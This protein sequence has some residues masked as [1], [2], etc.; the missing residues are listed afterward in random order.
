MITR[1]DSL[2]IKPEN[3]AFFSHPPIL[4]HI[5]RYILTDEEYENVKKFYQT[6]KLENLAELN[7]IYN[8]QDTIVLCEIFEQHSSHLQNLFKFNLRKC[9][10]ASSSSGC[11]H[12]DKSK[13]CIAL[14]TDT[15]HVRVFEKTL[16]GGFSCVNTRLAF[17]TEILLKDDKKNDK[18]LF[19]LHID[20]KKQTKR[21]SSK[22]LKMDENNQYG[23]AMT[24]PLSYSCMK[25]QEHP[26]SLIEFNKILDKISHE[27]DIGHLFIVDKKFHDVNPKA[28][29]F[30]E[31]YPPIFEKNKKTDLYKRSTLQ[32]M[33]IVVRDEDKYKINSLPYTSKTHSTLKE[34]RFIP[35]YAKDLH[36]LVNHAGWL[37]THIYEHYTFEQSKFKKDFVV[38]NQKSREKAN[39]ICR[40]IFFLSYLT[41]VIS[42]LTVEIT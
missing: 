4:F 12:R 9:N 26:L 3:S 40:K 22:I 24:K 32:L 14:P 13:C 6:L 25:K 1:Y 21:I 33:S 15:E 23:K 37:V 39:F 42:E 5:K 10:S 18:V 19:D 30:N 38:M 29:L 8:F 20:S 31:I 17:D 35:L 27:D 7:K 16:I 28:L 11:V 36:F 2:D 34:K 41:I